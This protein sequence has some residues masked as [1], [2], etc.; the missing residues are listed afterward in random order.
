[1]KLWKSKRKGSVLLIAIGTLALL[2]IYAVAFFSSMSVERSASASFVMG[3]TAENV[4]KAGLERATADLKNYMIFEDGN[5]AGVNYRERNYDKIVDAWRYPKASLDGN[6]ELEK[7]SDIN[8]LS[9][10]NASTSGTFKDHVYSGSSGNTLPNG[11]DIYRLK[12]LDCSSMVYL[13][14]GN[15]T[16]LK[17]ILKNLFTEI[18]IGNADRFAKDLV[19]MRPAEGFKTK[20]QIHMALD[21]I[22]KNLGMNEQGRLS[23]FL[24][25]RDKITCYTWVDESQIRPL[26]ARNVTG[27]TTLDGCVEAGDTEHTSRILVEPRS[28]ININTASKEVLFAV[29][30]DLTAGG[31]TVNAT[32]ARTLATQII[33]ARTATPFTNYLQLYNWFKTISPAQADLLIANFNSNVDFNKFHPEVNMKRNFDK[34]DLE[35]YSTEFCFNSMGYFEIT[36]LGM[37]LAED[38]SIH[39]LSKIQSVSRIFNIYRDTT[40]SDFE[41]DRKAYMNYQGRHLGIIS[42]PE[43]SNARQEF[44]GADGEKELRPINHMCNFDG[45]LVINGLIRKMVLT[46][47]FLMG[48]IRNQQVSSGTYIGSLKPILAP[49]NAVTSTNYSGN[50]PREANASGDESLFNP[51]KS[52]AQF[53][54]GN[55]LVPLGLIVDTNRARYL[56]FSGQNMPLEKGTVELWVKPHSDNSSGDEYYFYWGTGG[57]NPVL[58]IWRTSDFSG[59][60]VKAHFALGWSRGAVSKSWGNNNTSFSAAY[61]GRGAAFGPMSNGVTISKDV[62]WKAGE[63]HHVL[64]TFGKFAHGGVLASEGRLYVDGQGANLIVPFATTASGRTIYP[65][66]Y[67]TETFVQTNQISQTVVVTVPKLDSNGNQVFS[68]GT[69]QVDSEGNPVLDSNG[70]QVVSGQTAVTE[71]VTTT[72]GP[73]ENPPLAPGGT[74]P[75]PDGRIGTIKSV[76]APVIHPGAGVALASWQSK[77]FYIGAKPSGSGGTSFANATI[78]NVL[79]H[80]YVHQDIRSNRNGYSPYCRY[81]RQGDINFPGY[82]A[83]LRKRLYPLEKQN[84]LLGNVYWTVYPSK[85]E[86]LATV[87]LEVNNVKLGNPSSL[88]KAQKEGAGYSLKKKEVSGKSMVARIYYLV[89]F[90]VTNKNQALALDAFNSSPIFDDVTITYFTTPETVAYYKFNY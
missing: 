25:V 69:P 20:Q 8:Q 66:S 60:S 12:V 16:N 19:D 3:I 2:V 87:Q 84:I 75:A 11:K 32:Q 27:P 40:Q 44:L 41:T 14:S 46:N 13:N 80:H 71:D 1:M 52:A 49:N 48:F 17:R 65:V 90:E 28:P 72:Y 24:N 86:R 85:D 82:G 51:G 78:D 31:V 89:D 43:F 58:A 62:D 7:A 54:N 18:G 33:N 37:V 22:G 83:T 64:I 79:V 9:F 77:D 5:P 23:V 42:L 10:S 70:N 74:Y 29:L 21:T 30:T 15:P 50:P 81:F 39:G 88:I 55:D 61:G 36:S 4:A 45:Q 59:T 47:D 68:G 76:S 57:N 34:T 6:L 73:T 67:D 26:K 38:G 53:F 63:W 56:R 35:I